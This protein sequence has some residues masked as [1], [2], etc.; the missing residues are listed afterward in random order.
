MTTSFSRKLHF[1]F[2]KYIKLAGILEILILKKLIL[3]AIN[4]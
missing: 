4:D 2:F 1:Q 3:K